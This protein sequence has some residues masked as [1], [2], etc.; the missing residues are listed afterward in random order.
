MGA[1]HFADPRALEH[2]GLPNG[3]NLALAVIEM[4]SAILFFLGAD[5]ARWVFFTISIAA[6]Y[7]HLRFDEAPLLVLPAVPLILLG[8]YGWANRPQAVC[9]CGLRHHPP[10]PN[11]RD[12]K[13]C[14]DLDAA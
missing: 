13:A 11:P 5:F 12:S 10:S 6:V 8:A 14:A 9:S 7:F 3:F 2:Y 4:V 1:L